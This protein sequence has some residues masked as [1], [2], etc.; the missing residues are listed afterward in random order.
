VIISG[1]KP[2]IISYDALVVKT[3]K[4]KKLILIYR[5]PLWLSDKVVK[6]EKKNEIERTR[7]RSP[8]RATYL[9]K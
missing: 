3:S 2:T 4:H 9:K 8:P 7:V 1:S 6:N 5:E